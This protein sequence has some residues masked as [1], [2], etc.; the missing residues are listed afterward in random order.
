MLKERNSIVQGLPL[1]VSHALVTVDASR[2]FAAGL[3][4]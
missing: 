4:G 3:S 2:G 1:R